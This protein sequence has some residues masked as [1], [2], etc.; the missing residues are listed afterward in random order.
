MKNRPQQ[1]ICLIGVRVSGGTVL[2]CARAGLLD[3]GLVGAGRL[4]RP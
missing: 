1:V 3:L 2:L 4:L